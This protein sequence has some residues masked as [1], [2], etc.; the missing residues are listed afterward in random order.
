MLMTAP[1]TKNRLKQQLRLIL[2][3]TPSN[4]SN[5]KVI[6]KYHV[7]ISTVILHSVALILCGDFHRSA[8]AAPLYD[9]FTT[10]IQ[11]QATTF[12][13]ATGLTGAAVTSVSALLGLIPWAVILLVG[14]ISAWQAYA[15][16]Q[17]YD[18]EDLSGMGKCVLNVMVLFGLTIMSSIIT[19]FIVAGT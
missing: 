11:T 7:A 3:F 2:G 9:K 1:T 17:A 15:G 6:K 8:S 14:A 4:R 13:T 18:R 5:R 12:M 16:Y 19:D 10:Y